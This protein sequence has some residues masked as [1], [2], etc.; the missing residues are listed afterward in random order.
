MLEL[1]REKLGVEKWQS[2]SCYDRIF[3]FDEEWL[4]EY[5]NGTWKLADNIPFPLIYRPSP[6]QIHVPPD[7]QW[8][9]KE[10][11]RPKTWKERLIK[12][13]KN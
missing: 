13:L 2:F 6:K 4:L 10:Y 12:W 9:Y 3:K 1:L 11:Y 7:W 5:V 8:Y